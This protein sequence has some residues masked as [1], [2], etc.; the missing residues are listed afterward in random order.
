[1]KSVLTSEPTTPAKFS[2]R[3]VEGNTIDA[4]VTGMR[5]LTVWF[6]KGM[7]DYSKPVTVKVA[8]V[9]K[10]VTKKIAP[11]YRGAHGRPL[12]TRRPPAAVLRKD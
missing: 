12:R 5:Q 7:L 2:A 9:P 3:I 8:G 11:E 1:M 6:G 4:K 10:P